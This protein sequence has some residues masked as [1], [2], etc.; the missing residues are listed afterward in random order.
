MMPM[1]FPKWFQKQAAQE[2][3]AP[4]QEAQA[5]ELAFFDTTLLYTS[6]DFPRYNPD[7]VV[8]RKGLKFYAKIARDDQAKAVMLFLKYATI[9]RGFT[10]QVNAPEGSRLAK[11]QERFG[12]WAEAMVSDVNGTWQD[13][14]M[15]IQSAHD[16]GFSLSEK[17]HAPWKYDGKTWLALTDLKLRPAESFEF[18]ADD[19]G[20]VTK[21]A[22]VNAGLENQD[23]PYDKFLHYVNRPDIDPLHG[24]SD[25]RACYRPWW[26]KDVSL[27]LWSIYLERMAGGYFVATQEEELTP[28]ERANLESVAGNRQG[29]TGM[30]LPKGV[31]A[32][33]HQPNDTQ[34]YERMIA[35]QDK[36]IAR[37][38]LMPNLLGFSEQ[39]TTGSF[40]QSKSQLE[41]FFFYLDA[42]S[43]RLSEFVKDGVFRDLAAWNFGL[44]KLPDLVPN[45]MTASQRLEIAKEWGALVSQSAA[46]NDE[47]AEAH[48]RQLMG[49]PARPEGAAAVSGGPG[50][51]QPTGQPS[52][53]GA[54]FP[55][56]EKETPPE[57]K[58]GEDD[59][60]TQYAEALSNAPPWVRR[61]DYAAI[62]K[63]SLELEDRMGGDLAEVMLEVWLDWLPRI[64]KGITVDGV[65]KLKV[66]SKHL[67]AIRRVIRRGLEAGW[68]SGQRAAGA[69]LKAAGWKPGAQ[70]AELPGAA[71]VIP[72]PGMDK[73]RAE[74]FLKGQSFYGTQS[75][76]SDFTKDI[77]QV[78]YSGLHNDLTQPEI[79]DALG[80]FI[81]Q[82]VPKVDAAGRIVNLPARLATIART[83]TFSAMNQSR[84][85]FYTDTDLKGFV[86]G[87]EFSAILDSRTTDICAS[88]N[89]FKAAADDPV[90]AGY[91][92]PLHFNCRSLLI[93][94]TEGD[95]WKPSEGP[96][97]KK[98][99][100]GFAG[101]QELEKGTASLKPKATGQVKPPAP[102][103]AASIPGVKVPKLPPKAQPKALPAKPAIPTIQPVDLVELY[104]GI[105]PQAVKLVQ[106]GSLEEAAA[107]IHASSGLK[108][109]QLMQWDD[110]MQ[111][112]NKYAPV[113]A[114]GVTDYG[115][116]NLLRGKALD[117]DGLYAKL[118]HLVEVPDEAALNRSVT[119]AKPVTVRGEGRDGEAWTKPAPGIEEWS[120]DAMLKTQHSNRALWMESAEGA[121]AS[122]VR[123]V[124]AFTG[125]HYGDIRKAQAG[126][127][128]A[129]D[130]RINKLLQWAGDAEDFI[131]NQPAYMGE[132]GALY[133]SVKFFSE[134]DRDAWLAK[135][136]RGDIY[137]EGALSSYS[138]SPK[139]SA[140]WAAGTPHPV[141]IEVQG[142][143][144]GYGSAVM[145]HSSHSHELEV[146][147]SR[148]H[149][150]RVVKVDT[151]KAM[152][153]GYGEKV[154]TRILVE[155]I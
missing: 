126:I 65:A 77:H 72:G 9:G 7:E 122:Q 60:E 134:A 149:Q 137:S 92:P 46:V 3:K 99:A 123:G 132:R 139:F 53:G 103:P 34:A 150:F 47:S 35:A 112:L 29:A 121:T 117:A 119:G 86:E 89:G 4:P 28:A 49:Y 69:E 127:L 155:E 144:E 67:T 43:V 113:K 30:V 44:E 26:T 38:L 5:G 54:P 141:M 106:V 21:I 23:L 102:V 16:Y 146:L 111:A 148:R 32:E 105:D 14:L 93:P 75:L 45:P 62:E 95:E 125:E 13:K 51:V 87:L 151:V 138:V 152:T 118:K 94:I 71:G 55:K 19:H 120:A 135:V 124:K 2:T 31:K 74:Q 58:G 130:A 6:G 101:K 129:P 85:N 147:M 25:L 50:A 100:K 18:Y 39:G 57:E 114:K 96:P 133:R 42:R 63:G 98:P 107:I 78:L 108:P 68:K 40:A 82:Y 145:A 8:G 59:D 36:A 22:Q 48:T 90:W 33:V 136:V 1:N 109:G 88:N 104:K 52:G 10:W 97:P 154:F 142:F 37:L 64:Q 76:A 140:N 56:R 15:G 17:I 27:K 11:L 70:F 81:G 128:S 41:M 24:E 66:D 80:A 153:D 131:A 61:V 79:A 115:Y 73:Y 83:N 84:L 91:T 143:S 20:N 110:F 12:E 116:G